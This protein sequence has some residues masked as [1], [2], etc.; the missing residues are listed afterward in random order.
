MEE[1]EASECLPFSRIER[2]A[3]IFWMLYGVFMSH[4]PRK[5]CLN[6]VVKWHMI[7][8]YDSHSGPFGLFK[9]FGS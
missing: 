3:G 7:I 8:A 6:G 5:V 2:M 4:G 9:R 1:V